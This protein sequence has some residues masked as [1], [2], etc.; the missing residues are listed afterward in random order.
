MVMSPSQILA[1]TVNELTDTIMVNIDENGHLGEI[2]LI[3]KPDVL[4]GTTILLKGD[5]QQISVT[6]FPGTEST[7]QL[8][9]ANQSRI[10]ETLAETGHLP[11]NISIINS[12]GRRH[13]RKTA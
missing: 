6:F 3:L 5:H 8:L 13:I 9:M 7:E 2:R 1:E 4:D 11:V 12:E 10:A